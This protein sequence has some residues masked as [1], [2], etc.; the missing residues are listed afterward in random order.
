MGRDEVGADDHALQLEND[1]GGVPRPAGVEVALW[2]VRAPDAGDEPAG[3]VW[4][5]AF[6]PAR[7]AVVLSAPDGPEHALAAALARSSG[8]ELLADPALRAPAAGE[9]DSALARRAWP[10]LGH[11]LDRGA[12]SLVAVLAEDVLRALACLLLGIPPIRAR[13]LC[14]DPGRGLLVL[15]GPSGWILRHANVA[16]AEP[17]TSAR[18]GNA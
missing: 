2:L 15:S 18:N 4:R 1:R 12:S 8:A 9:D 10:A 7:P 11:V 13:A 16:A 17:A 3:Q 5:E 14:I 6:A